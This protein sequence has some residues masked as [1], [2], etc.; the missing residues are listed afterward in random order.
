MGNLLGMT[1]KPLVLREIARQRAHGRRPEW[2]AVR[3]SRSDEVRRREAAESVPTGR[4]K[5]RESVDSPRRAS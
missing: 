4:R 1:F 2:V 3:G 5:R